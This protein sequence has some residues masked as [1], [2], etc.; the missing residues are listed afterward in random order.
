MMKLVKL[1]LVLRIAFFLILPGTIKAAPLGT[2]DIAKT[3]N[4]ASDIIEVWAAGY[5]GLPSYSGVYMLDKTYGTNEGKLWDDGPIGVFCIE[6][7]ELTSSDTLTYDVIMPEEG[8]LPTALLGSAMGTTKA[9]YLEE[10]WGRYF[11]PSWVGNGPFTYTQNAKAAAFGAAAWE[12][13]H[14][15]LPTSPLGWDVTV[16]GT[17]GIGGFRADYLDSV[18][19]NNML[20]SLDGTGPRADLRVFSYNGQQDYIVAVPEPATIALIGIGGVFSLLRRKKTTA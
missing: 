12:I 13:V 6:W 10:L 17:I 5:E 16:D 14:E 4:G 19:A 20:H 11:D 8:P 15:N 7:A 2:V 18:A 1:S 3:S 9:K